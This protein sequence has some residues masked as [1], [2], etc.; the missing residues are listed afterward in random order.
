MEITYWLTKEAINRMF[1]E[2]GREVSAEQSVTIN[3]AELSKAAREW[4]IDHARMELPTFEPGRYPYAPGKEHF[5]FNLLVET[6]EDVELLIGAHRSAYE[7]AQATVNA[8][9]D[10]AIVEKIDQMEAMLARPV[11]FNDYAPKLPE[12]FKDRP[13]AAR[14]N[15]VAQ[16]VTHRLQTERL[17]NLRRAYEATAANPTAHGRADAISAEYKQHPDY[18]ATEAARER[19]EAALKQFQAARERFAAAEKAQRETEK[20][21]WIA[22]HGSEHLRQAFAAG[23]NSQ[24]RYVQERAAL[25]YPGYAIDFDD[26]AGWKAR[27]FP[28]EAALAEALRVKG[29]VVWLTSG[30]ERSEEWEEFTEREAVVITGYLGKYD[31]IK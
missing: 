14:A 29:E 1:V 11:D 16:Q 21:A 6:P 13:L 24:R 18:A 31:L 25:E 10:A 27:S 28:S 7:A 2:D 26:N 17:A 3:A 20:A 4:L 23:Y 8:A 19:A 5:T 15:E 30:V 12:W 9:I 22:E